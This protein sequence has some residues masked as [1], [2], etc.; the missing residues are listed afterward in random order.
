MR[1][2]FSRFRE[3]RLDQSGI[4]MVDLMMWLVIAVLLLAAAL[5]GIA[6]YQRA[7]YFYDMETEVNGVAANAHAAASINGGYMDDT[8]LSNVVADNNTKNN[9]DSIVVT[10]GSILATAAGP[11]VGSNS[12]FELASAV[13][14]TSSD[15]VYYLKASSTLVGDKYVVYFFKGTNTYM[16]GVSIVGK[17]G[18]DG[19]GTEPAVTPGGGS[20]TTPVPTST[21]TATPTPTATA[22]TSPTTSPTATATTSPTATP[23]PT[24]TATPT[25]T[26]PSI[27]S[28]S[29]I[30]AYDASGELW[31][32]GPVGDNLTNRKSISPSGATIPNDFYVADWNSDG[33]QDLML[34]MPNGD[35]I[36]RKGLSSGGFTDTK[37]GF[38]WDGYDITIGKWKSTDSYPSVIAKELS[39]GNLYNYQN[40][41]GTGFGNKVAV[42]AG[43][44]G[45]TINML[46]WDK[47]GT[48]DIVARMDSTNDMI[49]YRTDGAGAFLNEARQTIGSGWSFNSMHTMTGRNGAGTVGILA[50]LSTGD[51]YYYPATTS[52]W[53]P[54]TLISGGWSSYKIAGN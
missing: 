3:K 4:N 17:S 33:I 26:G 31:D 10:Y 12:S 21:T 45:Y 43:W 29:D 27:T 52:T 41:S 54:R 16:Q 42:G 49:L 6:Y 34:K 19:G 13:T 48:M 44:N 51:L 30:V 7:A 46:D 40:P 14:A 8:V 39:T 37:I 11:A 53:A 5:Q 15:A 32:F 20:T 1:S 9:K 2:L 36:F 50:R 24:A 18:I 23:T 28:A 47:N 38:G 22:T 35:F 25:P